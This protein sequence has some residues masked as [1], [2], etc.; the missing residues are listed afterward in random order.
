MMSILESKGKPD[1][2]TIVSEHD[3]CGESDYSAP[4]RA[5]RW[6]V[7]RFFKIVEVIIKLFGAIYYGVKT[8]AVLLFHYFVWPHPI[9]LG[10]H[11]FRRRR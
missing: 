7:I 5:L 4:A 1:N 11:M 6:I 9:Y 8:I 3:G 2:E 10:R